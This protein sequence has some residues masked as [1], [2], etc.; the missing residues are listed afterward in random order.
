MNENDDESSGS[1]FGDDEDEL[2]P[3]RKPHD[4][5]KSDR[6]RPGPKETINTHHSGDGHTDTEDDSYYDE[7]ET[8]TE[9][10]RNEGIDDD[11]HFE[12]TK[13]PPSTTT[14]TTTQSLPT[15]D[16]DSQFHYFYL[17]LDLSIFW[18]KTLGLFCYEFV[19]WYYGFSK[20]TSF[21][22]LNLLTNP[23]LHLVKMKSHQSDTHTIFTSQNSV[24]DN[25]F[26]S[27]EFSPLLW[28]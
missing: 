3:Q 17:K 14:S 9:S 11:F 26:S 2:P 15:D 7:V 12:V 23:F 16:E 27:L 4:P 21:I 19:F 20:F 28:F 8:K 25:F 18:L 22:Y 5:I 6:E 24:P 13:N 10:E 1:G